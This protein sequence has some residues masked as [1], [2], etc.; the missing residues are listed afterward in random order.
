MVL[1]VMN[2]HVN[3]T[4]HDAKQQLTALIILLAEDN[5]R[6]DD[7]DLPGPHSA[8]S[9]GATGRRV[10]ADAPPGWSRPGDKFRRV[11]G[12]MHLRSPRDTLETVTRPVAATDH[13]DTVTPA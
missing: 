7:L 3:D 11:N 2:S 1:I 4:A 12:Q 5:D 6:T 8:N 13:I 9:K 10:S